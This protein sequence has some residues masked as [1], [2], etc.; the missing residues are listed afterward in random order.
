[1]MLMGSFVGARFPDTIAADMGFFA[2]PRYAPDMP[3]YEEAPLDVLVLPANGENPRSR[4]RFLT[5]L[6]E[7]GAL[8]Q[9]NEANHTVSPQGDS[10]AAP[11]SLRAASYTIVNDA[12]GLTFFF[13]RDAKASMI[14]PT[15]DALR[16]FLKAPHDTDQAVRSIERSLRQSKARADKLH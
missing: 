9:L 2:F 15:F 5:F 7:S 13:D 1:M 14:Q 16:Q 8:R 4:K 12:A 10:Y 3:N 11:G 6:A